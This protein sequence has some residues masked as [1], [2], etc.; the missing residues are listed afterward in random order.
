MGGDGLVPSAVF[1]DLATRV[2]HNA[3]GSLHVKEL[4]HLL[5]FGAAPQFDP[6]SGEEADELL[7]D[8]GVIRDARVDSASFGNLLSRMA[9]S[10]E[11]SP[12]RAGPCILFFFYCPTPP[13]PGGPQFEN[14]VVLTVLPGALVS[15]L[16]CISSIRATPCNYVSLL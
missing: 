13:R 8:L 6:L 15:Q 2:Y 4:K 3:D 7:R 14:S 16:S 10:S 12:A 5:T 9:P 1:E 11:A